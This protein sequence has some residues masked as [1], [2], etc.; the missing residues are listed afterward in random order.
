MLMGSSASLVEQ[1]SNEFVKKYYLSLKD[2]T[3]EVEKMVN[4]SNCGKENLESAR[5]CRYCA[6]PMSQMVSQPVSAPGNAGMKTQSMGMQTA[7]PNKSKRGQ[8]SIPKLI[9]FII[10][11]IVLIL[12]ILMPYGLYT[13]DLDHLANAS[14]DF[15]RLLWS[16]SAQYEGLEV[17]FGLFIVA[18]YW[19][20]FAYLY[21]KGNRILMVKTSQTTI[22]AQ[23]PLPSYHPSAQVLPMRQQQPVT[24]SR[25]CSSCGATLSQEAKFCKSCGRANQ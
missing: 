24:G 22:D 1:S 25:F 18:E 2:M 23:M 20:G 8:R 14:S 21:W 16:D 11:G 3:Q 5:F 10:I 7:V 9:I 13:R 17:I 19:L 6:S 4:C 12:L 15:D